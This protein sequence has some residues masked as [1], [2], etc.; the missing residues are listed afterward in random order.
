MLVREIMNSPPVTIRGTATIRQAARLMLD[1]HI[2]GL[3]VIE[4]DGSLIGIVTE[5]DFL[6]RAELDTERQ[7]SWLFDVLGS[8]GTKADEYVR[9]HGRKVDEV[10]S[11]PVRVVSPQA[12]VAHAVTLMER[13]NV[14]RLPVVDGGVLVGVIARSDLIRA[15]F[16]FLP[17][18]SQAQADESIRIA[19]VNDLDRQ[20][21]NS[22]GFIHVSVLDGVATLSGTIL[23]ECERLAARVVTE[24]VEGVR[25]VKDELLWVDPYSG[26]TVGPPIASADGA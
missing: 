6:H 24:N 3:P 12:S 2:S 21:W 1:N 14:K 17:T 8:T 20:N 22:G 9:S 11:W 5:G 15:L 16:H 25:A 26:M 19:I 7:H 23:D 13:Y 10:M 18:S 4:K